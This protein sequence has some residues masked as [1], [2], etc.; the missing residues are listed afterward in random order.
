LDLSTRCDDPKQVC[1]QLMADLA[2]F[3]DRARSASIPIVFT[4]SFSTK[5]TAEGE[6]AKALNRRPSELVVYPD[7]FD[8]FAGGELKSFL[9]QHRA[10]NLIIV[11]SATNVAVMYTASAAARVHK[12]NVVIPL[13]GVNAGSAYEHEYA[14]HQLSVIP[15]GAA[16]RIQFTSLNGIEFV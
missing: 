7:A 12:Y 11:G 9:D 4:V 8:K 14:L 15:G 2:A 5:G 1:S 3:L 6:V 13:D 16:A 10:Q